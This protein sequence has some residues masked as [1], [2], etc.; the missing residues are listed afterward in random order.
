MI[1]TECGVMEL[2]WNRARP[3]VETKKLIREAASRKFSEMPNT[4][5]GVNNCFVASHV[6]SQ[7]QQSPEVSTAQMSI[8]RRRRK[9][10][11][12]K[13]LNRRS[14]C[15]HPYHGGIQRNSRIWRLGLWKFPDGVFHQIR[16]LASISI[17]VFF[18]R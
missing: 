9:S 12:R 18:L 4:S 15:G 14:C 5:P 1:S 11:L 2:S 8:Q 3:I 10:H 6:H 17:S 7:R 16:I 13:V